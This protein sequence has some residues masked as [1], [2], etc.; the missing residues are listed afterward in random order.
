MNALLLWFGIR[1]G[2][3]HCVGD[4]KGTKLV[5]VTHGMA[6]GK[7]FSI[8]SKLVSSRVLSPKR[9]E[10]RMLGVCGFFPHL[11]NNNFLNLLKN[12][13]KWIQTS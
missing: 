10:Q 1:I 12:I 4:R 9:K 7:S 5:V 8:T 13:V 2:L 11:K 3:D 6:K